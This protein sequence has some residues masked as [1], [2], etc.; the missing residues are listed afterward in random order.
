MFL[1]MA[2]LDMY[3]IRNP[4]ETHRLLWRLFPGRPDDSR[5]F[6]FRGEARRRGRARVLLQSV[7]QPE[8]EARGITLVGGPK[9]FGP[10]FRA[11]QNLRFLLRANPVKRLKE[12]RCRVPLI[13]EDE[14]VAW[15]GRKLE[16]AARPLDVAVDGK[17]TIW[18]QKGGKAGKIVAVTFSGILE[19]LDPGR[20][21]ELVRSGIGPAKGFGCGLLSLARG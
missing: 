18:F 10:S 15:L 14:Q 11:G 19:V 3:D 8:R 21:G 9:E 17:K 16:G 6:L 12:A 5:P 13:R 2:E 1:S 7:V 20:L 4:Y